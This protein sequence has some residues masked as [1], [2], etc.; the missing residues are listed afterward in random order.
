M[1]CH[2]TITLSTS[3]GVGIAEIVT[4]KS[5]TSKNGNAKTEETGR[6]TGILLEILEKN[7]MTPT[8]SN[9]MR[10]MPMSKS[11]RGNRRNF[12]RGYIGLDTNLSAKLTKRSGVLMT[13][14]VFC[15]QNTG[16]TIANSY[17]GYGVPQ[18]E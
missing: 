5:A 6:R 14:N 9:H 4:R 13:K 18:I 8:N 11:S 2:F 16:C 15:S 10:F 7:I 12:M 3:Y 1:N 17:S